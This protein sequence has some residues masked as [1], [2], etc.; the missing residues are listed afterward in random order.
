MGSVDRATSAVVNGDQSSGPTIDVVIPCHNADAYLADTLRS[1]ARQSYAA[2]RVIVVDDMSTDGSIAIAHSLG[3]TVLT[4]GRNAGPARARNLGVALSAADLVAFVDADDYWEPDH[5]SEIARLARACPTADV[6]FTRVRKTDG[7]IPSAPL[8]DPSYAALNLRSRLFHVNTVPQSAVAVRRDAFLQAGGYDESL[9]FAEDYELWLRM[10]RTRLFACSHVITVNYR[11]HDRQATRNLSRMISG[12]WTARRKELAWV[13]AQGSAAE[14]AC[15]NELLLEGW[16]E[17]LHAAWHSRNR[18]HLDFVL[19][20]A[21]VV[22]NSELMHA[23]WMRRRRMWW[24]AWQCG[25]RVL[26]AIPGLRAV[27][28]RWQSLRSSGNRRTPVPYSDPQR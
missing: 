18:A 14:V 4:T 21:G 2:A 26:D 16:R 1:V 19:E 8:D 5:L 22:P 3:A 20:V 15:V 28:R 24:W 13:Q 12:S 23:H 17:D 9:R 25:G 7:A 27:A 10:S 6:Y 11:I